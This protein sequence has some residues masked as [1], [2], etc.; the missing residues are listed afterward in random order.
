MTALRKLGSKGYRVLRSYSRPSH[1]GVIAQ[2]VCKRHGPVHA[3]SD[4]LEATIAWLCRSQ[5]VV[6]GSGSS[7]GYFFE[8]GWG[9]PYPETTGYIIPTLLRYADRC[10]DSSYVDRALSMGDWEIDI[11]LGYIIPTLLRYADRCGDSSYV[12]RALSMGDWEIV[13]LPS[14]AVRGGRGINEYPIVFNTGQV[15][16]GWCSLYRVTH[17]DRFLTAAVDAANWLLTVQDADGKWCR[18][19]FMD[20]PHAYHTRVA[21]ALLETYQLAGEDRHQQAAESNIN[22]ALSRAGKDGWLEHMGF[23]PDEPPLTHTIAYTLRGL[24]ESAPFLTE[25]TADEA[26]NLVLA[27]AHKTLRVYELRKRA[28]EDVPALFPAAFVENWRPAYSPASCLVGNAQMAIVWLKVY[29]LRQDARFLNAA[30]KMLDQV[31]QTQD[32]SSGNAGIRGGVAGSYPV[33]GPYLRLAYPNW[34]AKFFAD[35]LMLQEALMEPLESGCSPG[36]G[37]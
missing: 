10:G 20:A 33:W 13:Q 34:G 23:T 16:L 29:Q 31:K 7:S 11:Q 2:Q 9:P 6:G 12:D 28:P 32:L 18:H 3:D 1:L 4:H 25:G 15:M 37:S 8:T 30:L 21:W 35:A 27:A 5:D 24:L 17:E 19:S 36:V 26:R 14:G 22:W